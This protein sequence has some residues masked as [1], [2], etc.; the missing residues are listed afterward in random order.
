MQCKKVLY[1]SDDSK[2]GMANE[3]SFILLSLKEKQSKKLAQVI[4]SDK[5]RLILEYMASKDFVTETD[6][7]KDLKLPLSTVHYNI[8]ALHETKMLSAEEFHYSEKGKE[9]P[10]YKLANK[11]II[12]AP[13]NEVGMFEKLKKFMPIGA[14]VLGVA[15]VFAVG[16]AL[17]RSGG[18]MKAASSFSADMA[19]SNAAPRV[20]EAGTGVLPETAKMMADEAF[21]E[22]ATIATS[23][24]VHFPW[25]EVSIAFLAGILVTIACMYLWKKCKAR[26]SQK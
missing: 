14:V 18:S 2:K 12:I 6:I 15:A 25:L 20:L 9:V 8:K 1:M 4:S 22:T 3:E 13:K 10:H 5:C 24:V 17:L 19:L 21:V 11:F 7:A 16:S 23:Q 26:K